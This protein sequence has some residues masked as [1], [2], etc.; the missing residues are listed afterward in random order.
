VTKA[1]TR[2]DIARDR[3][4]IAGSYIWAIADPT[5]NRTS[6]ISELTFDTRYQF[7]SGWTGKLT[8]RY[9]FEADQ[10]TIAGLGLEFKN[11]CIAVDLSLSRR[12]TSS[13]SVQATTDFGLSVDL[14]GFGSGTAAGPSR[15]CRR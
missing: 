2:V 13:T 12:F 14:I 7:T 8:G 1:E 6:P 9:D 15:Q 5:E 3:F 4:G 10:G 11:E